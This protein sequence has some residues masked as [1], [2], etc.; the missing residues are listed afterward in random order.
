M[1]NGGV[2]SPS[3]SARGSR[4]LALTFTHGPYQLSY[5]THGSGDNVVVLLHGILLDA[6]VN[7]R[8][9]TRLAGHGY[10]VVL[11]DLLGHGRSDKPK[12]ASAHRMD[13]YA[14]QVVALLDELGV[15]QAVVGGVS[16][17]ADVALQT[18]VLAPERVRALIVEM[19]VL[20]WAAPAA[21]MFFVPA[22]LAFHYAAPAVRLVT[23][24][25]QRLPHS[26]S[27]L[28]ESLRNLGSIDPEQGAAVLHGVLLGP[29]APTT[30]ERAAISAP[31]LVIG[32]RHDIIH[33]FS[34]AENLL[35]QLPDARLVSARSPG[36]L[37]VFPARLTAEIVAFLSAV[38]ESP[39]AG[40]RSAGRGA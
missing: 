1:D 39:G 7:R 35:R 21:A 26:R 27:D 23:R 20:E 38:H 19:P 28:V 13:L 24:V 3:R 12:H 17:G 30:E 2:P 22:L 16:L 4:R 25:V 40:L 10:R 32:H 31:T 9:A 18:A 6:N 15:D 37:R 34:D 33:P 11:L 36:E 8:L 14:Q 29:I 5:E